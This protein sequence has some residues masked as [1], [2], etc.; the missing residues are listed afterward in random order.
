MT[1]FNTLPPFMRV[2]DNDNANFFSAIQTVQGLRM[3]QI[4]CEIFA[5]HLLIL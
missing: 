5:R 4:Q 1:V 3:D 2:G